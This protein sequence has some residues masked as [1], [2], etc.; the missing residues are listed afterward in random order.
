MTRSIVVPDLHGCFHFLESTLEQFSDRHLIFLGDFIHRGPESRQTLQAVLE[1]AES[2][3]ATVLWGNHEHWAYTELKD[4]PL[5]DAREWC[6][7]EGQAL[8]KSYA[9]NFEELLEDM[10][11]RLPRVARS[12]CVEGPMLCAHAARPSFGSS[13]DQIFDEGYLWDRPEMGLHPLPLEFFPELRYSVHGH[14]VQGAPWVD[15]E[16]DGV[17]YLDLG[18][19]RT[20]EFC[21]WDAELE[22][23]ILYQD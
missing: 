13:A 5:A 20:G 17:V 23:I 4:L 12:Y 6:E 7:E 2:G 11:V 8:F 15:L 1:L 14:T 18:G 22:Q 19:W 21:V 16:R 10:C 3:R 9:G